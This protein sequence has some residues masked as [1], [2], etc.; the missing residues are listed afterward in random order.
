MKKFNLVAAFFLSLVPLSVGE[1]IPASAAADRVGQ[2]VTVR[3]TVAQV[4]QIDSGMTFLNFGAPHPNATF[5][6]VIR[7]AGP[8]WEHVKTFEGNE[9]EVSGTVEL[10]R[11]KPQ[12]VLKSPDA[13]RLVTSSPTDPTTASIPVNSAP[14]PSPSNPLPPAREP[15]STGSSHHPREFTLQVPLTPEEMKQAGT[16]PGNVAPTEATVAVRLPNNFDP[17]Q[18]QRVLLVFATDDGG[19]AHVRSLPR[20]GRIAQEV[21]WVAM[22]ANG[23][24]LEKNLPPEWHATMVLAGLRAL[25]EKYPNLKTWSFYPGG[26]S[27][28]GLRSS[29]M[30]PALQAAGYN[31]KGCFMAGSRA[32]RFSAGQSVFKSPKANLRDIAV[33]LSVGQQDPIVS[34]ASADAVERAIKSLG[35]RTIKRDSFDGGHELN[36]ESLKRALLWFSSLD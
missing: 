25:A 33:F 3:G 23:P 4:R 35:V 20:L 16:S 10:F 1:V 27:G 30:V 5:T 12:I 17:N 36:E 31:V 34:A 11:D 8:G 29:M 7:A 24:V 13:I 18:P 28:G 32:E 21:G 22:A 9:V 2:A 15:A 19:G 14:T 26:N 6:A